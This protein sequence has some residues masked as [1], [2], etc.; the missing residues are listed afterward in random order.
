MPPTRL[1]TSTIPKPLEP[2]PTTLPSSVP[3]TSSMSVTIRIN[4]ILRP[5]PILSHGVAR[6]TTKVANEIPLVKINHL[7]SVREL[8]VCGAAMPP[9]FQSLTRTRAPHPRLV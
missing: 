7:G 5:T 4:V 1:R 9:P 8:T 3:I 6:W 2:N